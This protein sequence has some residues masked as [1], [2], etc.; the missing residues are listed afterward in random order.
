MRLSEMNGDQLAVCLSIITEPA[1][2]IVEDDE[3]IEKIKGC[4]TVNEKG[5]KYLDIPRAVLR[6]IP[7]LL[8]KHKV[9]TFT[10][11]GAMNGRTAEDV[12]KQNGLKMVADIKAVFDRDLLDFFKSSGSAE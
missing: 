5:Q 8:G 12:S 7:V 3:V 6:L 4:M 1:E 2:R 9:D 10:I 11:L